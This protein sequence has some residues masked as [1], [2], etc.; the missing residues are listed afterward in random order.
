MILATQEGTGGIARH[1]RATGPATDTA[2]RPAKWSVSRVISN[3]AHKACQ[4]RPHC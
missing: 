3:G 1:H 2:N 4:W